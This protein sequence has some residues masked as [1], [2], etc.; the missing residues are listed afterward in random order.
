MTGLNAWGEQITSERLVI[1]PLLELHAELL[2]DALSEPLLYRWISALPPA[3]VDLLQRRWAALASRDPSSR[4]PSR[5]G[6]MDLCWAV[7]RASDGAYVGKLDAELMDEVATNVGYIV[8]VPFWNQGYATEAMRAVAAYLEQQ[9]VV[10]QRAYVT[11]GNDASARVLQKAGFVKTR[12]LPLNDTIRG[13]RAQA[14]LAARRSGL[15]SCR[16]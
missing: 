16:A 2:F 5:R 4:D 3:S 12:V 7:R 1:E 13:V 9:G 10:E 6:E 11:L 14:A 8:F 15:L